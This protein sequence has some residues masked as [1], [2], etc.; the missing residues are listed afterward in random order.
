MSYHTQYMNNL[1]NKVNFCNLL[2]KNKGNFNFND[3][4]FRNTFYNDHENYQFSGRPN[5]SSDY[6][7][8]QQRINNSKS[9]INTSNQ[10]TNRF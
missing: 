1:Q 2:Q 7:S 10:R 8:Q 5:I 9:L 3:N 4:G 6:T